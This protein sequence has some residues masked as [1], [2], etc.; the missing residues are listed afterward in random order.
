MSRGSFTG[1]VHAMRSVRAFRTAS[2]LALI[3]LLQP[4]LV[5]AAPSP[6]VHLIHPPLIRYASSQST[7]WSGYAVTG[8]T[9]S[10]GEVRASW[11]VPSVAGTCTSTDQ[12]SSFWVG[13]DG[14]SSSTVEQTGTDSDCQGG[15][16]TY[17]AWYEFYPNPSFIISGIA[18]H[19]GDKVG[20]LVKYAGGSFTVTIKDFTGGQSF[21]TSATVPSAQRNSAEWIAEAPSDF[22]GVLPLANFGTADFGFDYTGIATTS[23]ANVGGTLAPIGSYG[24]S[25]QSIDMVDT[26]D[27][28]IARTSALSSDGNS[29]TVQRVTGTALR[30]TTS[31]VAPSTTSET[32]GNVS[33]VPFTATVADTGSGAP[34]APTGT[35]TWSD[36]GKGGTFSSASCV[37]S[38]STSSSSTCSVTYTPSSS[39]PVGS[40][41]V[42]ASYPGDSTHSPSSGSG[43][44][45]ISKRSTTASVSPSSS[46]VTHGTPVTSTVTVRDTSAGSATSPTGTVT[47]KVSG[48]GATVTCTLKASGSGVSTCSVSGALPIGSYTLTA[49]YNGDSTHST[50]SGTSSVTVT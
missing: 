18:V 37:L 39:S 25:I 42:T 40:I 29:F 6:V 50:S 41:T 22:F 44:I 46:T 15:S 19:P 3:L 14:F 11:I 16:P 2:I 28:V 13:I 5:L 34:S 32:V 9:G 1:S 27:N 8:T 49:T 24:G 45:A 43:S 33:P 36:G 23:Y 4:S 48:L 10:V 20:A 47:W 7:N 30:T 38:P 26:S 31:T 17:Y 12:Y 21:T 35:V